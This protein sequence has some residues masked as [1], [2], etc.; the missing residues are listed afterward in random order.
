MFL[1]HSN[2]YRSLLLGAVFTFPAQYVKAQTHQTLSL[3]AIQSRSFETTDTQKMLQ[4]IVSTLQDMG[5]IIGRIDNQ[6]GFVNA[7]QFANDI[8][9]ITVTIQ[10]ITHSM[11]VRASGRRN[12]IPMDDD[13]VFYQNFFNHLSQAAFLNAN[14]IY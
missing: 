11:T 12:N 3:R 5:Y 14:K 9:E 13:P 4:N 8:T 6:L 2:L 10:P 7:A 1:F